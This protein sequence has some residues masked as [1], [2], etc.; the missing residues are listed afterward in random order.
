MKKKR[1]WLKV[2]LI[3]VG[4]LLF[5]AVLAVVLGL[6]YIN[7]KLNLMSRPVGTV[8]TPSPSQMLEFSI[9]NTDV[10]PEDYTGEIL[11][12]EDIEWETL[13]DAPIETEEDIVNILLIGADR[14]V[15]GRSRSDAMILCTYNRKDGTLL[16][17]SFMRDMYLPIPGYAD[18][19]INASYFFGGIPLLN[20]CIYQ[21]FGIEI[22][23]NFLVDFDSFINVIDAVDGVDITLTAAEA[24][25]MNNPGRWFPEDRYLAGTFREGV[26]RLNGVAALSY[27]RNRSIGMWDFTRTERQ[28]N[29]LS[30][31]FNRCKQMSIS[32]LD[33]LLDE[34]LPLVTTD[35]SNGEIIDLAVSVIPDISSISVNT[36]RIPADGLCR[37]AWVS[38]MAVLIPDLERSR[39]QLEA[40]IFG[41][42]LEETP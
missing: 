25:Y 40:L 17:T 32:Q 14:E 36:H 7:S 23:G 27:A 18:N 3:I 4:V 34:L 9:E 38:G 6:L 16:F 13:P 2:F 22:D 42:Q 29:V 8:G 31:L 33:S 24:D 12:P 39:Q 19:R 30:S 37:D 20:K 11:N 26:N 5:L 41:E 35:M 10:M 15:G 28:R 21:N 1:T